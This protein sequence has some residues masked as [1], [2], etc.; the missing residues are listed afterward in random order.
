MI[1]SKNFIPVNEIN[2]SGNEKKYVDDCIKTNWISSE[3]SYVSKFEENFSSLIDKK[4]AVAVSSGT[5]ALQIAFDSLNL[6]KGDEVILPS[7]TIVSCLLPIIRLNLKPI[8]I[9]S[10]LNTWNMNVS[11]IENKITKKTKVILVS[12]IYGLPTEMTR[13]VKLAKKNK[14]FI[15]ED[16][17]EAHG[18][19]YNGKYCGWYG[20]ISIFSFYANKLITTGEGG[21]L[22]TNNKKIFQRSKSLRNLFFG[23]SN[24]FKHDDMGWNYRM[25]NIQAAIG[26]AQLEKL[27]QHVVRKKDIG[28]FYLNNIKTN[29]N[30][31]LPLKTYN[32]SENVYWVFGIL[33]KGKFE[34]KV[35][36]I[37]NILNK[38]FN[39]GTRPFFWPLHKQPI[40]KNLNYNI[41]NK[42]LLNAEYISK[43]GFY[44]PSGIAIKNSDI[45]YIS[46]V[47]N[48][49]LGD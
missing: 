27:N 33:L 13:I 44:I 17:A 24:R 1:K 20:D 43:N 4:Y 41:N 3:G 38:K 39:I 10:D 18:L 5:A 12:H 19:K 15:I 45:K 14:I 22:L 11:D 40:L 48:Y 36:Y 29:N 34:N 28:N 2:L 23:K 32:K 35:K 21:M 37:T 26:C 25:T 9:D 16:S 30:F 47:I 46:N 8:F 31:Q 6:K 49:I 42:N 7:F